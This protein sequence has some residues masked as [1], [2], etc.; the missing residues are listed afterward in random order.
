MLLTIMNTAPN[1]CTAVAVASDN[2]QI[3]YAAKAHVLLGSNDVLIDVIL[4]HTIFYTSRTSVLY[5][6]L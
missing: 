3:L 1:H 2:K 6:K 4:M 5:Y